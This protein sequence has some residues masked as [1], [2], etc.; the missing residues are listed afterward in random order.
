MK[1]RA[2]YLLPL[3]VLA[4]GSADARKKNKAQPLPP[5]NI[6]QQQSVDGLPI[7]TI[8]PQKLPE[9]TCTAF[10]WTLG[11]PPALVA[12][13]AADPTLIRY[14]PGG[15]VTD[16]ALT[17]SSGE[18][19]YRLPE[20]MTFATDYARVTADLTIEERSDIQQGAVVSA[21]AL[22][23]ARPGT[24]AVVVPVKGL[25]GCA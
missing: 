10:L 21:G 15:Q 5:P 6:Q 3:L 20:H 12:M 1:I 24:D 23:I 22:T 7:G 19:R 25:V 13:I 11:D 4:A 14:A 17:S 2:A 9:G 16:M 18:T 8:P